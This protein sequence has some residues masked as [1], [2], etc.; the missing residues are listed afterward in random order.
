L[1]PDFFSPLVTIPVALIVAGMK[2]HSILHIHNI[3]IPKF[4]YLISFQP[5]FVYIPIRRYY[6]L[7][8]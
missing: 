7:Y 3:S 2:K 6:Y 1:F 5:P 4:L 8:Q